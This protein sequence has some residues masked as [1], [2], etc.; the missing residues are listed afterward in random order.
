M[1]NPS[2]I[3]FGTSRLSVIVLEELAK[4]GLKPEAIITAIDKPKGRKLV[5]SPP[6]TKVYGE[7]NGIEVLQFEKLGPAEVDRIKDIS[8]IKNK[9][10]IPENRIKFF[11]VASYGLIIPQEILDIPEFGTI[12]IHPSLLPKYRGATPIQQAILDDKYDTGVTIM[13][14]DKKMDH[15][16]TLLQEKRYAEKIADAS[17]E[18]VVNWPKKYNDLEAELALQASNILAENINKILDG[19]IIPQVQLH[20]NATF[21]KKIQKADGQLDISKLSGPEGYAQFLKFN[22]FHIWPT[23]Y[24]F[25]P[26]KN[27][28]SYTDSHATQNPDMRIKVTDAKWNTTENKME[29][30]KVIPEGQKEVGFT[31]FLKR[32]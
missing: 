22:A 25:M 5:L 11:L 26:R 1:T 18:T 27:N 6:E 32:F 19:S 3:F 7:K 9:S 28:D 14:M 29:I 16:P 10:N 17:I 31:D 4:H 13:L 2:F 15:G 8:E 20:E 12:N 21:T 23:T 24:F 30:L